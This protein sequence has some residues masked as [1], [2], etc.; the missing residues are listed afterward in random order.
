MPSDPGSSKSG[1]SSP[2]VRAWDGAAT[3]VNHTPSNKDFKDFDIGSFFSSEGCAAHTVT[4]TCR[5]SI[6]PALSNFGQVYKLD[7]K[8]TMAGNP[9]GII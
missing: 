2:T 1:A 7:S 8:P 3:R 4:L 5:V 9:S 6:V